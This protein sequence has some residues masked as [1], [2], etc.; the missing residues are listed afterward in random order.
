VSPPNTGSAVDVTEIEFPPRGAV[1][2]DNQRVAAADQH[3]WVFDGTLEVRV[4]A[5]D[6]R[7]HAGDCLRMQFGQPTLFR[8]PT[9]RPVRYAVIVHH[10]GQTS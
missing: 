2:F 7:L 5:D 3:I 10:G 8:N 6:F 1:A 4:G 9:D